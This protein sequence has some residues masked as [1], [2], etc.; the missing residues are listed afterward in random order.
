MRYPTSRPETIADGIIHAISIL[1]GIVGAI[2]LWCYLPM[3]RTIEMSWAVS[4]YII[5][6][7][8][9]FIV[10]GTY[11]MTPISDLR[12]KLR[13]ADHAMI[14]IRIA[15]TQTPFVLIIN[16]PL[17]YTVLAAVWVVAL[18]GFIQKLLFWQGVGGSSIK[19]YT[20]LSSAMVVLL[21]QM[22]N[23]MDHKAVWLILI[24][25]AIYGVGAII[26]SSK[27]MLYRYP[28]WHIFATTASVAFYIAIVIAIR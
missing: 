3:W 25:G 27:S 6:M 20:A 24:G 15:T 4:A 1:L 9:A 18:Y 14:F 22:W 16:T 26:Y 28:V 5:V 10:S 23:S 2:W 11:H 21:W 19:L 13:R 8:G 17:A 7:V 12:V